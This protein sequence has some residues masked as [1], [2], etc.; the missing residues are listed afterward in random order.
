MTPLVRELSRMVPTPEESVWF[1]LGEIEGEIMLDVA[2]ERLL[3]LPFDDIAIVG[4]VEGIRF[5]VRAMAGEGSVTLAGFRFTRE[6]RDD[7]APLTIMADPETGGL[8]VYTRDNRR[9]T[10]LDRI[11]IAILDCLLTRLDGSKA[12]EG[13]RAE[14]ARTFTARRQMAR[15][16]TPAYAWRTVE[17][18]ARVRAD[19][20]SAGGS[21]A[22]PRAHERRGHWRTLPAGRV[23]VRP[24]RVGDPASGSVFHDYRVK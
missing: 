6:A 2:P 23:W 11:A 15:G 16:K 19:R 1:D 20:G 3:H 17:V 9:V 13:Y 5:A 18:T 24:C 22:S 12:I 14:V 8:R 10:D 21:H 4:V 7:F